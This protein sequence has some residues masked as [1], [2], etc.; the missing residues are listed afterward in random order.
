MELEP[1]T[2]AYRTPARAALA[3]DVY[4]STIRQ[5][6]T[7]PITNITSTTVTSANSTRV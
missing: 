7:T 2:I 3:I 6:S 1:W 4:T 5:T